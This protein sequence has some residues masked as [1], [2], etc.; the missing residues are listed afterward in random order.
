[1]KRQFFKQVTIVCFLNL[2]F[3]VQAVESGG[4]YLSNGAEGSVKLS[5]LSG[6]DNAELMIA[7]LPVIP[8]SALGNNSPDTTPAANVPVRQQPTDSRQVATTSRTVAPAETSQISSNEHYRNHI[9]QQMNG[10]LRSAP[11]Q[12]VSRRYLMQSRP[13]MASFGF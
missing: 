6:N 13:Q 10:S 12:A 4:I 7:E 3:S 8:P 1:M 5:N 2:C 9:E 11:N